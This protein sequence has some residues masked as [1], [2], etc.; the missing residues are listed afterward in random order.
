MPERETAAYVCS[1]IF[2][3]TRPVL[4]VSREDGDWQF[5][6]GV[7]TP[8]NKVSSISYIGFRHIDRT[9]SVAEKNDEQNVIQGEDYDVFGRL[10]KVSNPLMTGAYQY[11][12]GDHLSRVDVSASG[13]VQTRTF[14]YDNRGFLLSETHP[15]LGSSG[16]G[17]RRIPAF[18]QLRP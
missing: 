6:C 16:G 5:L 3:A 14:S 9:V 8:D 2:A 4:L 15:E 13:A 7:T 1:H 12:V 17:V 11:D 18:H 10:V